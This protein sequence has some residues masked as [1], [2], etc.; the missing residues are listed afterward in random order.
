MLTLAPSMLENVE[1]FLDALET[2][3][4][5]G[6][7]VRLTLGNYKGSEEHLQKIHARP[8][9]TKK[10]DRLFLLYRYETRDVAKNYAVEE[11]RVLM[12][13]LLADGFRSGHLFTTEHD[14]QLDIGKNGKSRLNRAK[15]TF[16]T[17]P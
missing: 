15:P 6:T 14:L 5:D 10:G 16:K 9:K 13:K 17:T 1:K 4:L 3:L 12:A 2:S 11:A 8:V 7:F